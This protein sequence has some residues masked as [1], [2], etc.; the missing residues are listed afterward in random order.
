MF[1]CFRPAKATQFVSFCG[2]ICIIAASLFCCVGGCNRFGGLGVGMAPR[3]WSRT[4]VLRAAPFK[5]SG[6]WARS[7]QFIHRK[8]PPAYVK[9]T[10]DIVQPVQ[11]IPSRDWTSPVIEPP[12]QWTRAAGTTGSAPSIFRPVPWSACTKVDVWQSWSA[13]NDIETPTM[14]D[15]NASVTLDITPPLEG[16][17]GNCAVWVYHYGKPPSKKHTRQP[18]LVEDQAAQPI[19]QPT[20]HDP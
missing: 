15:P 16:N 7:L 20:R 18:M 17:G 3:A 14:K 13:T 9:E 6:V 2:V 8:A 11:S 12:S 10:A 1:H 5:A 4:K 19:R